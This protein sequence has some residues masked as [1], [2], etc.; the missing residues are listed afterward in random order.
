MSIEPLAISY[1]LNNFN[2][3]NFNLSNYHYDWQTIKNGEAIKLNQLNP[4]NY[5][6]EMYGVN[7]NGIR[8]DT[9]KLQ[10]NIAKAWY[11]TWYAY[12]AYT[13][14][15]FLL[16]I[17]IYNFQINQRLRQAEA[18]RLKELDRVKTALYTNITHEFRT[19]LTVILGMAEQ[20]KEKPKKSLKEGL[21][22]IQRS[23]QHLLGLV[24]QMLD[25]AKV[26]SGNMAAN[27]V[28]GDIGYFLQYMVE[29]FQSFTESRKIDLIFYNETDELV[30]DY[31][32]E[33]LQTVLSNL[34]SNAVK[35]TPEQGKI[36]VHLQQKEIEQQVGCQ[37]KI[38][39]NGIGIKPADLLHIFDRFYQVDAAATQRSGGTGIG[40]ALTKE[41]VELMNGTIEVSSQLNKGSEFII[42]LPIQNTAPFAKEISRANLLDKID[43]S[44]L[45]VEE[46]NELLVEDEREDLPLVL[47]IEDN[48]DVIT[49]LQACLEDQYRVQIA[50]DGNV[51]IEKAFEL[52]P[53]IIIS[54]V[55]MPEKD[56]YE[57]CDILKN[58]ERSSHIPIILLTAKAQLEARL[59]GL[60]KGADAYLSKPFHQQEL[61]IRLTQL[62]EQRIRL[63]AYYSQSSFAEGSQPVTDPF[64]QKI[65]DLL[66]AD[67]MADYTVESFCK[68]L[69]RS[70]SQVFRKVKAVTGYSTTIFIRRVRLKNAHQL[71]TS[72]DLS[73]SE[74]AYAV[75]FKDPSFFSKSY[76]KMFGQSPSKARERNRS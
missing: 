10:I 48:L 30:M 41:L 74:I 57:V 64:I 7:A 47:I 65:V 19:P 16:I 53:D 67:L 24:N 21:D 39:D 38:Q 34:L 51:G 32:P 35:F 6:L 28:Q 44:I 22:M 62:L 14:I 71:L 29:S 45:P 60:S 27:Y 66:E 31:D 13:L 49:Y 58:D 25:L 4:G 8:G 23:G 33:K 61:E 54:D 42:Q 46:P 72:T 63:Q 36:I 52:V 15:T 11:N 20:I 68:A 73:V 9:R 75:G 37:I 5:T 12:T 55:M 40:L 69:G 3:I 26:E 56:G 76:T 50:L 18:Y 1:Y 43:A 59:T 2:E 70:R 17:S